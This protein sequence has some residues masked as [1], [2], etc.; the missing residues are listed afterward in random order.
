MIQIQAG[1]KTGTQKKEQINACCKE[2]SQGRVFR[3]NVAFYNQNLDLFLDLDQID[4]NSAKPGPEMDSA[5][6]FRFIE[7]GSETLPF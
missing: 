6:F 2:L 4:P 5:K 3:K 7:Y 1:K